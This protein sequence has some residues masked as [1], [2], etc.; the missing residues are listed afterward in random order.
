MRSL[1]APCGPAPTGRSLLR[2]TAA[3]LLYCALVLMLYSPAAL[4]V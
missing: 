2:T 1:E 3:V 4:R